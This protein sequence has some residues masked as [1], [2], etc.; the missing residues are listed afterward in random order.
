MQATV[1]RLFFLSPVNKRKSR[2]SESSTNELVHLWRAGRLFLHL[3][4]YLR[5]FPS[6]M[7]VSVMRFHARVNIV[8]LC[9]CSSTGGEYLIIFHEK[10]KAII[11]TLFFK[12]F[13]D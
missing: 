6:G 11:N 4:V 9:D 10:D 12:M 8:E 5:K 7:V 1:Y 3:G 2:S 13:S